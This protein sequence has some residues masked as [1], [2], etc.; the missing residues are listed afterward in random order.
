MH[1][2]C[3]QC[4]VQYSEPRDTCMICEDERQYVNWDG[5]RW[6]TLSELQ[7][8]EHRGDIAQEGPQVFGV[9]TWPSFAIGQRA[10]LIQA[11]GGNVLWDCVSYL[12]DP[13]VGQIRELGGIS[14][15]AVSHPHFYGCMVEWART[16]DVP[17]YVHAADRQW[18]T[19]PDDHVVFWEGEVRQ[20]A[21]GMTLINAGVHFEG[22]TVLH[23]DAD[24][25]AL[26]S[27]DIAT[28]VPDRA[29]VSFMRSYPNLIPERPQVIRRAV[30]LLDDFEFNRIYGAWWRRIVDS[31]G[32]NA[33][34]RSAERY[35]S[36]IG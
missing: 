5:Q 25:G 12:D 9:G 18:V 32:S 28:V 14:A 24:G 1:P 30:R 17:V 8:G 22:G 3:V 19:R 26:F 20:M 11:S 6:T 16:F 33:V 34:R 4:G 13:L 2:I 15:I 7:A 36:Q 10:L 29:W 21:P 31:D 23:W 35:L 27:G